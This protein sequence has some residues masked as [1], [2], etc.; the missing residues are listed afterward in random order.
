[1]KYIEDYEAHIND[2]V[3]KDE[4]LMMDSKYLYD[5]ATHL[6]KDGKYKTYG[7]YENRVRELW[8]ITSLAEEFDNFRLFCSADNEPIDEW[9]Q[10]VNEVT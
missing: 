2:I 5:F 8:D 9:L 7:D 10:G 6:R 1:M 3:E 4:T